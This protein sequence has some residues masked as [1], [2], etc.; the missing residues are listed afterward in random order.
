MVPH[1][2]Y[3][4][5]Y[6]GKFRMPYFLSDLMSDRRAHKFHFTIGIHHK[7]QDMVSNKS[8][9]DRTANGKST[10]LSIDLIKAIMFIFSQKK[11]ACLGMV[12]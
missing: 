5:I 12:Q 3:E 11:I 2:T 7:R 6:I 10:K 4:K 9:L 8:R 1:P